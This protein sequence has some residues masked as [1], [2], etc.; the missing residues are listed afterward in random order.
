MEQVTEQ[1]VPGYHCGEQLPRACRWGCGIYVF[2]CE[3]SNDDT[4]SQI[5]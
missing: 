2:Y 4:N 5:K 3:L 1:L